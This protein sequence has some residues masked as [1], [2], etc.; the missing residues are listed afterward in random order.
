MTFQKNVIMVL[1]TETSDLQGNVYDVGFVIT[2]RK[3][4]IVQRVNALVEENFEDAKKMMGAFFAGKMFSHYARMLQDDE[5]RLEPWSLIVQ[6]MRDAIEEHS[7]NVIS[8]YNLAFD[9]RVMRKT[10]EALGTSNV[11]PHADFKLLDIWR[12]AC[13]AKLNTRLYK[14]VARENGWVSNAGNIRTGAE[15]AYRFCCGNL[16]FVEDHTAL[17]DAEIENDILRTCF[18]T[19]KR[20]PYNDVA[21]KYANAPWRIVNS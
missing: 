1:D 4:K 7:V 10:N 9:L 19:R 2:D 5:I 11:L 18:A 20:I 21:D 3:G 8:A 14:D 12:F 17:S 15:Y 13:E 6:T 16:D